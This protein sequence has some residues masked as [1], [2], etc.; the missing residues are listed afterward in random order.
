[1]KTT[2][3]N[4]FN[5]LNRRKSHQFAMAVSLSDVKSAAGLKKL[6]E[7]LL[8]RSYISGLV[9]HLKSFFFFVNLLFALASVL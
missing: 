2:D 4:L 9:S 3:V 5:F 1:M 6:D 7:Y 8:S